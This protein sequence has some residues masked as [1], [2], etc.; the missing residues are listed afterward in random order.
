[1]PR[2]FSPAW[3]WAGIFAPFLCLAAV[4]L[5]GSVTL[6]AQA[7]LLLALGLWLL[8]APPHRGLGKLVSLLL[9]GWL[10]APL[11]SFAPV[12]WLP[13]G[14]T[15]WRMSVAEELGIPAGR[16]FSAQP[17]LSWESGWVLAG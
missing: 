9:A 3:T 7:V 4:A 2:P 8:A 11:L 12:G 5:G 17:W 16:F 15:A 10:L 13:H 14:M 1:M 6:G